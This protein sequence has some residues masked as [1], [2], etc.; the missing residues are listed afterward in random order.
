MTADDVTEVVM[1]SNNSTPSHSTPG[2]PSGTTSYPHTPM[3]T[4]PTTPTTPVQPTPSPTLAFRSTLSAPADSNTRINLLPRAC[5]ISLL[6]PILTAFTHREYNNTIPKKTVFHGTCI[7]QIDLSSYLNRLMKYGKLSHSTVIISLI[8]LDRQL[9]HLPGRNTLSITDWTVHRI[10]LASVVLAAKYQD[11]E[12]FN[13]NHMA[14]VGGVTNIEL[15]AMEVAMLVSL[16]FSLYV[17]PLVF[18]RYE[19]LLLVEEVGKEDD[20]DA[21]IN[22]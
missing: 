7:P 19:N 12:Y 16:N 3:P 17:S 9:A 11:D 6:V 13:N 5:L 15:N 20:G 2:T 10:L 8:Y 18:A 1:N 4:T 21:D 14:A 22:K